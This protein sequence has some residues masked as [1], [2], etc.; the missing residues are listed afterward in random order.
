MD[1]KTRNKAAG[2]CCE[3]ELSRSKN[4]TILN[5]RESEASNSLGATPKSRLSLRLFQFSA[6]SVGDGER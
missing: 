6:E 2:R 4:A 3:N 1:S 5:A